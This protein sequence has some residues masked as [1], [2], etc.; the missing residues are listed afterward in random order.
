MARRA[1]CSLLCSVLV[2]FLWLGSLGLSGAGRDRLSGAPLARAAE[3][4]VSLRYVTQVSVG[5]TPHLEIETRRAQSKLVAFLRR[6]DGRRVSRTFSGLAAGGTVVLELPAD[7]GVYRYRGE[8]RLHQAGQVQTVEI[9][10]SVNVAGALQI[11]VD[12]AWVDLDARTLEVSASRPL[13]RVELTVTAGVAGQGETVRKI[14]KDFEGTYPNQRLKVSWP[15]MG[16]PVR[17]D[18]KAVDEGGYY[19]GLSL[20][21][22]RIDIPHEEVLFETGSAEIPPSQMPKVRESLRR[23]EA[24]LARYRD[25]GAVKLFVA[26]HTDTR[27]SRADNLKLSAARARAIAAVF[28]QAQLPL[29]VFFEGFGEQALAVATPDDTDE[30]ANRRADYILALEPPSFRVAGFQPTWR[31]LVARTR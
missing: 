31:R 2:L 4:P 15:E 18:V 27:G 6:S 13:S 24:A 26:G 9:A 14:A 22:W 19:A 12:R 20:F 8:L 30:A 16:P 10:F 5:Q 3:A 29:P 28:A 25:L 11:Q 17:I 23:I 7:E 21:P 1:S